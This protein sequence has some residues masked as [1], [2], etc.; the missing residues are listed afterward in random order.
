VVL[1]DPNSEGT[2]QEIQTQI[3]LLR[4]VRSD[5]EEVVDMINEIEVVRARMEAASGSYTAA[6]ARNAAALTQQLIELEDKLV[7]L[8]L[9]GRGQDGVRWPGGVA[10]KLGYLAGGIAS[11]DFAP[12]QQQ[13]EVAEMF[14]LQIRD[15]KAE[16]DRLMRQQVPVMDEDALELMEE[17]QEAAL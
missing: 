7:P 10:G 11:S 9:T 8:R 4:E 15:H 2:L 5:L 12:T 1:K 3:A 13:R 17:L 14:R 6:Q 16:F